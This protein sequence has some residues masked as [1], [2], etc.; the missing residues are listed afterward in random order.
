MDKD[1]EFFEQN[2]RREQEEKLDR[3][4]ILNQ[5]ARKGEILFTGS[6]L[7]EQFPIHETDDERWD[8]PGH[9]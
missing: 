3:F 8:G 6:S 7:M 4:R 9:L 2:M 1:F 5:E